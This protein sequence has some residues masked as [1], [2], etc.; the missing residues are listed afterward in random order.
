[1]IWGKLGDHELELKQK[2]S[3]ECLFNGYL[4]S[5]G[6]VSGMPYMNSLKTKGKNTH[7]GMHL[8]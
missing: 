4:T 8:R 6:F 3:G 7:R 2:F 5:R 1:V